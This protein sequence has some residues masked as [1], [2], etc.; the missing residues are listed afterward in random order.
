MRL[1]ASGAKVI[2]PVHLQ[3]GVINQDAIGV[4]GVRQGWC[5]AVCDGLGS[6]RLSH[7]GSSKAARLVKQHARQ[8]LAASA[9][10]LGEAIRLS[11]LDHFGPRYRD[12]ETTCLWA[13]VDARG[14][15]QAGKIGDG[16]LLLK[17]RGA[18]RVVS[19]ARQGFGNQTDTLAQADEGLWQTCEFEL[20]LPG[21]GVLLM[22][23]G[24]S[25]DLIPEQWEPFFDAV[26][27]R[28]ARSNRRRMRTWLEREMHAWSTPLHGDDKSIAGIFR[29]DPKQ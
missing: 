13:R 4:Y 6:R 21:D 20:V 3:D 17:S 16:L 26:Y 11:W 19:A 14:R 2:G 22:T 7:I 12:Y 25:D 18:F 5:I 8:A 27:R 15:G 28:L 23:D 10:T 1:A 9:Q 24:I 29:T